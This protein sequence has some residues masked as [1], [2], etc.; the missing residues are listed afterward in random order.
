MTN[1][2]AEVGPKR[3]ELLHELLPGVTVVGVLVEPT[4]PTLAE[5]FLRGLQPAAHT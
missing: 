5:A 2:N 3:I 1:L 4:S